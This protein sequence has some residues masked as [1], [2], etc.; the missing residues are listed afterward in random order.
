L[1]VHDWRTPISEFFIGEFSRV[2]YLILGLATNTL[3]IFK[4]KLDEIAKSIL[5]KY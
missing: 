1:E 3:E 5:E 4:K 2:S